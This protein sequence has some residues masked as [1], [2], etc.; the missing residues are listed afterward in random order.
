MTDRVTTWAGA[1]PQELDVMRNGKYAMIGIAKLAAAMFGTSTVVNGLSCVPTTP[2][3]LTVNVNPGEIYSL[4]NIDSSPQSSLAADTAHQIMKS[5]IS[6]D[7]VNLSCPAPA[8]GGQSINYLVQAAYQDSDTDNVAL[9][10][11]NASNPTQAWIGPNNSGTAQA[12]TRKGIVVLSAKA[13]T[14]A[15]TGSQVTPAADSGYT[16]L[17]VVT[18]ANGQSTITAGNIV[19]ATNAP[20]LP[21]S[22][23]A[24]IQN[25]NLSYAVATGTANAHVVALTPAL[26]SRVD[27]MVIRYKAP[28]AN[29]AALTLNDGIGTVAVVGGAHA[30]LQGG[31]TIQNGDVWVQWNSSIGGGSY[32][33]L[34]SS[35]G[36]LQVSPATQ[37][38][39]AMQLGQAT[40]RLLRVTRYRNNAGTLQSSINGGA[41]ATASS[42]FTAQTLTTSV[43]VEVLGGGASGGGAQATTS[44]QYAAGSGG[45]G[46]GGA[47]KYLTSGFNGSTV[48]VGAGGAAASPG[49]AGNAGG[50]SSFGASV[51][52]TGGSGG[53]LGVANTGGGGSSGQAGAGIGS[54][55][56]SN[57]QGS[58]GGPAFYN[59]GSVSS[60]AGGASAFGGGGAPFVSGT[61]SGNSASSPGSGGSGG[62]SGPSNGTGAASGAGVGGEITVWEYA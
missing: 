56:D 62:S 35:G 22:L 41:Y 31:E 54:G 21:S 13:G 59:T 18:V 11:Y 4:I 9:P 39:H 43:Y 44:A 5:G 12:T 8:T 47:R 38:Q 55:G 7:V 2:A 10:Y 17:W 58:P 19:Q 25:G 48:T 15:T 51:S 6:L 14:A 37:S 46:G 42:T 34:D 1:I 16:G 24:S 32:I 40:G 53:A 20:I 50:S 28:A 60:G 30:A 49:V 26:T 29:N 23:L 3:G 27:G 57:L 61:S 36:A 45:G 33:M 52:A